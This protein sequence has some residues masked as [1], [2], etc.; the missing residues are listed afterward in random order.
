M[1]PICST[2]V[3]VV[4]TAGLDTGFWTRFWTLIVLIVFSHIINH[5]NLEVVVCM[6]MP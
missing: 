5:K 4:L 6:H 1:I 3:R 2:T